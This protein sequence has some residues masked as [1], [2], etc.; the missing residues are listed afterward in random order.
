MSTHA[1]VVCNGRPTVAQYT[2]I[3]LAGIDHRLDGDD[4]TC[5]EPHARSRLTKVRHLRILVH[6]AT[7]AVTHKISYYGEPFSLNDSLHSRSDIAQGCS[8]LHCGNSRVERLLR[9]CQQSRGI[10][11][12][13]LAYGNSNCGI[14]VV[15]IH[16][17]AAIH[18][19]NVSLF[20][21]SLLRG[22]AV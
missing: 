5:F 20:K 15:A 21:D 3:R 13:L 7:D 9:R 12:D 6:V 19:D 16:N 18:R 4:H 11:G 22:D 17:G 14:A 1:S 8:R 2:N 10:G